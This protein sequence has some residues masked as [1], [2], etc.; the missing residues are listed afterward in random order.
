MK[1]TI[2]ITDYVLSDL[3]DGLEEI[4]FEVVYKPSISQGDIDTY[5]PSVHGIIVNTRT[6]MDRRR[7][8]MAGNLEFIGRLG[9]GLDI[10]DLEIA[11]EHHIEVFST[12][13][14]NANAVA[15][16]VIGMILSLVRNLNIADKQVREGV[17]KREENRGFALKG[18]TL[19]I[20]GFGNNGGAL[21]R[22][23]ESLGLRVL[24][25]DKYKFNYAEDLIHVK[26]TNQEDVLLNSDIISMHVPLTDETKYMVDSAF[27]NCCPK[28]M[29]F[30]NT[31]RGQVVNTKDL[32]TALQDG[33]VKAAGLDVFEN[34]KP[35]T[36]DPEEQ[37]MYNKLH[38][39]SQTLLTPHIAGWTQESKKA[40]SLNLLKKIIKFYKT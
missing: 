8:K 30:I 1:K 23:V 16:H 12:P 9:S 37:E 34:E 2:L 5:L 35:E 13:E 28:C 22:K 24:A 20:I 33:K 21:G 6:K 40:I 25:Y 27:L 7:I 31:S 17:W 4:G 36:Y 29:V 11:Q 10:I 15:E 39:M 3:I 14:A 38:E 26:E 18:K 32:I 19:G